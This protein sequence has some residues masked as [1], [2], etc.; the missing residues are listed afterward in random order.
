MSCS[1]PEQPKSWNDVVASI[2]A[3]K[4][5]PDL[6]FKSAL[7]SND[8]IAKDVAA[9]TLQGGVLAY[10]IDE[11]TQATA[12]AITPISLANVPEKIQQIVD[13]AIWPAP[14][15]EI[16]PISDPSDPSR[17]VVVVTV[18]PSTLAPHYAKTRFPARS[19]TT[20][21]YLAEREIA[22]LYEQRRV[23]MSSIEDREILDGYTDPP[24]APGGIG[25]ESADG[26]GLCAYEHLWAAEMLAFLTIAGN[27]FA[28]VPGAAM[29][30]LDVGAQ[31]LAGAMSWALCQGL[32][33]DGVDLRASDSN[34]L[35]RALATSHEIL[36]DPVAVAR[37]LLD[38]LLISFVPEESDVFVRLRST[39]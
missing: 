28:E 8:E 7:T 36:D 4:E 11:D 17:G 38:R 18:P 21:R 31:G 20:T 33:L 2:G 24:N 5:A 23:V 30:R 37:R 25:L 12:S 3:I 35:E 1:T 27:F 29:L 6:D 19:G 14:V 32:T 26:A 22:A 39:V 34:Y 10:G 13:S 9:M 16:S 15:V